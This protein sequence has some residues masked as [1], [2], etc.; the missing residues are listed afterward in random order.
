MVVERLAFMN[1]AFS[2]GVVE[3]EDLLHRAT[4]CQLLR[5]NFSLRI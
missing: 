5:N 4:V 1:P 2:S 3:V